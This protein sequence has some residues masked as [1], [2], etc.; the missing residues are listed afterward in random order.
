LPNPALVSKLVFLAVLFLAFLVAH[1]STLPLNKKG[2]NMN[3]ILFLWNV[4]HAA[5]LPSVVASATL[6]AEKLPTDL[7]VGIEMYSDAEALPI[8]DKC[9]LSDL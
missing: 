3:P 9:F 8:V 2:F 7:F 6:R 1:F 4:L 5:H